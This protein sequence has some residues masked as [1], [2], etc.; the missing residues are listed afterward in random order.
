[1]PTQKPAQD[2]RNC[3]G[4]YLPPEKML[5]AL[6]GDFSRRK[7]HPWGGAMAALVAALLIAAIFLT[8]GYV[9]GRG[10]REP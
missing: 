3:R 6:C 5:D 9:I 8:L 10:S 1:M 4:V 7:S 2:E